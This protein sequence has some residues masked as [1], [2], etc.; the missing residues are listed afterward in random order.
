[1][2]ELVTMRIPNLQGLWQA[3]KKRARVVLDPERAFAEFAFEPRLNLAAKEMPHDLQ[4]IAQAQN[5]NSQVKDSPFRQRRALGVHTSGAAG[6]D[7]TFGLE[8]SNLCGGR[9]VTQNDGI[10]I[11]LTNAARNDLR[12]LRAEI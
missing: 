1:F 4:P 9:V 11:A 12:V 6:E 10:D 7:Q 8:R 5:R 3:G 2:R